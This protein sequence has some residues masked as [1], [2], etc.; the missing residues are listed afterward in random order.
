VSDVTIKVNVDPTTGEIGVS[1]DAGAAPAPMDISPAG[2]VA[3]ATGDAPGPT[4]EFMAGG[5]QED[6]AAAGEVGPPPLEPSELEAGGVAAEG[7]AA[8]EVAPPPEDL[9]T[10]GT[11]AAAA[12]DQDDLEPMP[13]ADLGAAAKPK[14]K[15]EPKPK[16][17]AEPKP[18]A[19][20]S[21]TKK[22]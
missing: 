22:K 16:A 2:P 17:K 13:L 7:I 14:A 3:A 10:L 20:P 1:S 18:K 5:P 19:R 11:D 12:P 4:P 6:D 21:A 8:G 15:A 9:G